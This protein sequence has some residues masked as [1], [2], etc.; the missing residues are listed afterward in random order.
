M[1]NET[2]IIGFIPYKDKLLIVATL[3]VTMITFIE[4]IKLRPQKYAYCSELCD[5]TA[6]QSWEK[7][8]HLC[9]N[10]SLLVTK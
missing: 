4:H 3:I 7:A 6:L 2:L 5:V 10:I 9:N 8:M 1:F